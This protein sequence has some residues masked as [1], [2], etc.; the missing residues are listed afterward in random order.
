M[1]TLIIASDHAG[2]ELKTSI[3]KDSF[4]NQLK[5]NFINC[6]TDNNQS[7]D[8]PDYANKA[9]NLYQDLMKTE[10]EKDIFILLICGSG[11]GVS[12]IANRYTFI[13]AALCYEPELSTLA[14]EHNNANCL[15]L[16]ARFTDVT[17]AKNIITSFVTTEFDIKNDRHV[18]R[19]D[20]LSKPI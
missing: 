16:G 2:F 8:Y 13:R 7:C 19:V 5:I 4:A 6:G 14:R 18:K 1:K 3:L 10:S 15:C 20:K 17:K 12:I 11:I 9:I